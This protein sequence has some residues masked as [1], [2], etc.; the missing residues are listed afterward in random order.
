MGYFQ[1]RYDS[2]VLNYERRGFIRLATDLGVTTAVDTF[3]LY[4]PKVKEAKTFCSIGPTTCRS[5]ECR[6]EQN[7]ERKCFHFCPEES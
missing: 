6:D 4:F 7:F 3:K 5:N 2:S 1:V